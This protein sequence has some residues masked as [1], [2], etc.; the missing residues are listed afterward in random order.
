[1]W[2]KDFWKA[3]AE[4]VIQGGA[5][6]VA[7]GFFGGDVIFNALN[8]STWLDVLSLFIGGGVSMLIF[9]LAGNAVS[10]TGPAF[11][12]V[13]TIDPAPPPPAGMV[14]PAVPQE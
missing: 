3:T 6:A 2:T 5:A 11:N 12:S 8:V 4:R 9:S 1:M 13:E 14:H 10:K 7:A